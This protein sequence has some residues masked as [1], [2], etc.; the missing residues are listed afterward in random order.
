MSTHKLF[1]GLITAIMPQNLQ[2]LSMDPE[3]RQEVPDTQ[4]LFR[5]S[6]SDVIIVIE[7][8]ARVEPTDNQ[9]A[10]RFIFNELA[11][12]NDANLRTIDDDPDVPPLIRPEPP[13]DK[14]GT[15]LIPTILTGTQHIAKDGR[16]QNELD[17]V[18]IAMCLFRPHTCN[19]LLITFNVPEKSGGWNQAKNDFKTLVESLTVDPELFASP[20]ES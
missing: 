15:A 8:I 13:P 4:E 19:D 7:V 16:A 3:R 2:D 10:V 6:Q 20:S 11:D 5:Y 12:V 17:Q 18:R 14:S 1:G 9:E